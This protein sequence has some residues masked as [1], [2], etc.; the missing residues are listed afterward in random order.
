[1]SGVQCQHI[2]RLERQAELSGRRAGTDQAVVE[3]PDPEE[4]QPAPKPAAPK[5]AP[6]EKPK[7]KT[8]PTVDHGKIMALYRAK[9][10]VA[11]IADEM[12]CSQQTI[13]NHLRTEA[14][15]GPKES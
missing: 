9:W 6:A 3:N 10:T 12:G 1:M 15:E 13:Y 7:Q 5:P 2:D 14:Q 4:K 11:A 8:G